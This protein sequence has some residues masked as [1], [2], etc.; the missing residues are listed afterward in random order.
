VA[1]TPESTVRELLQAERDC[2]LRLLPILEAERAAAACCDVQALLACLR[3]RETVQAEWQ[4]VAEERRQHVRAA[5]GEL[6]TLAQGD[7]GLI[8]LIHEIRQYA[9]LVRR[10][11]RVNEGVIRAVLAQV[12]DLLAVA[13]RERPESRYDAHA[14]LT[15]PRARAHGGWSA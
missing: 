2:C 14:A 8:A 3:E 11:Q 5:A 6:L 12:D 1:E 10:S 7:A 4:R 9:G 13:R 15:V